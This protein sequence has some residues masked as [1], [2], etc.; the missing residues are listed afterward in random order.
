MASCQQN[1][2]FTAKQLLAIEA[3]ATGEYTL[4]EVADIAEVSL[5]SIK[6]WK[7][8]IF[9]IEE[10]IKTARMKLRSKLPRLYKSLIDGSI[11]GSTPKAKVILDHIDNLEKLE[12]KAISAKINFTWEPSDNTNPVQS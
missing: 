5:E 12:T 4:Q 7:K 10:I 8:N 11:A 3:L 9:F 6:H 1:E 2:P